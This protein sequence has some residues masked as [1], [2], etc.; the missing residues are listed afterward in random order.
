VGLAAERLAH[1]PL[2]VIGVLIP[3]ERRASA[4]AAASEGANGKAKT[5]SQFAIGLLNQFLTNRDKEGCKDGN[6]N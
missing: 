6:R 4:S 5:G 2:N 3:H 1:F